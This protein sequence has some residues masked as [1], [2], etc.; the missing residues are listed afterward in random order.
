MQ[1]RD[2]FITSYSRDSF[3][4]GLRSSGNG[5]SSGGGSGNGVS[6]GGGSESGGKR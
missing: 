2:L 3:V 6:S 5:V 4:W 1:L